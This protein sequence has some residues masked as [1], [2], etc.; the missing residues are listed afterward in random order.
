MTQGNFNPEQIGSAGLYWWT[1]IIVSDES[2]KDNEIAEKWNTLDQL[3]GWGARYK[4]RIVGKHTG[5]REKLSDDKLELCEVVYPVTGGTGHAA[6]YQTSN[7]RQG[8]VVIG[9]YK[10][11]TDGNEPI[12]LGCIGNNDQTVLKRAQQNG[13]DTLSGYTSSTGTARVAKYSIPPGGSPR[14]RQYVGEAL[15]NSTDKA[16]N[17]ADQRAAEDQRT[18]SPVASSYDCDL[19]N[20]SGIQLK[21]QNLIIDIE[22]KKKEIYD[23]R[24]SITNEIISED[25]QS[26]GVEEYV[27]YKVGKVAG[28][29]TAA[30][31]NLVLEVQK[32]VK[33]NIEKGAKNFYYLLFPNARPKAKVAIET[34]NELITCLFRKIIGQLISVIT[35]FLLSAVNKYINVPLCA[36]ENILGAIIGKLSGLLNS[37]IKAIMGPVNAAL[38]AVDL[39]GDIFDIVIGILSFIKC[40]DPPSCSEVKEWSIYDGGGQGLNLDIGSIINKVKSFAGGVQQSVDP[41]NFDFD[42]DFGDVFD[43]PCNINAILCGPPTVEFFG[44]GGSGTSGNAIVS[45]SGEVLGVD[46]IGTGGGYSN[47]PTVRFVDACGKGRGAFGRAVMGRVPKSNS[48]GTGTGTGTGDGTGTGTGAIDGNNNTDIGNLGDNETTLGVIAVIMDETGTGYLPTPNGDQG[49]GGRTWAEAEDTTIQNPNGDW[50]IPVPPG[51]TVPVNTGDTV[52]TPPGTITPIEGTDEV[53]PGGAP[54]IVQNSGTITTPSA[55]DVKP[56]EDYPSSSDGSYPVILYLCG[57]EISDPGFL[58]SE[59]DA[60]VIEPSNGATAE[61][62]LGAF[63]LINSVKVTSPGEGFTEVPEIFIQTETGYNARL[64]PRFCIDRISQDELK[65]PT[66]EIQDKIISVIDCV[67]KIP[68]TRREFFRVPL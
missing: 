57:L 48:D 42:L 35:K 8:S 49:G 9:F 16:N 52:T 45:A 37:A 40:D 65:E 11:G 32:K 33:E 2:W 41:D 67:G 47:P 20:F 24:Y 60:V 21:I 51:N 62:T 5:V 63:G 27:A 53:I 23:W 14:S 44:G 55:P 25:G 1:G 3:P 26:F 30:I 38:K 4:V 17:A 54:Y 36:A 31:K 58:Y 12:I 46:I 13:F 19:I 68:Q 64:L 61:I 7:L 39:V 43:N 15:S 59:G 56:Y 50:Q 29:V 10:D 22:K 28:D 66:P 34:A 18:P 6:S